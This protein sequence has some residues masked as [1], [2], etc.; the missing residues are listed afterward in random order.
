M[1]VEEILSIGGV[2]VVSL[3]GSA[4]V[5]VALASWLG[6]IWAK[7][8]LQVENALLDAKLENLRHELGIIKSSYEHHL[9]LILDYYALFYKHYRLCHRTAH[10]DAHRQLPDGDLKFTKDVFLDSLGDFLF[11]WAEK[12]GRIRLLLPSDLLEIH[13]E[14]VTKFNEFKRAIDEFTTAEHS[15]RKK[16][17]I[18][19]EIDDIK[20][21]LESGLRKFLRTESLLK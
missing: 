21:R 16:E 4:F 19:Q 8:I 6:N 11:D 2:M 17:L 10:A 18:F 7:R 3:G 9:D 15:P 13:G 5:I 12:E 1:S 14:A 20:Y